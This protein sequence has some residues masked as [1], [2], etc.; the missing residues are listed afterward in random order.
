MGSDFSQGYIAH[1]VAKGVILIKATESVGIYTMIP[2]GMAEI[3]SI[4]WKDG[5]MVDTTVA[6]GDELG[7]F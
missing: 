7:H 3:S 2:I 5:L 4:V 1:C 6:K